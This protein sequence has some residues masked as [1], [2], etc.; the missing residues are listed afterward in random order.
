MSKYIY[1][2]FIPEYDSSDNIAFTPRKRYEVLDEFNHHGAYY[3]VFVRDDNGIE[4]GPI[5]IG[6]PCAY[7]DDKEWTV[8]I[9]EL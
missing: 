5:N 3:Q 9:E 2:D 6:S 7:L 4:R 8:V 1:S